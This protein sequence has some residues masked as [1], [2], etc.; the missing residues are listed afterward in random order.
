[1]TAMNV[2]KGMAHFSGSGPE[3]TT[4]GQCNHFLKPSR[5]DWQS[6]LSP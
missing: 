5:P 3:G 4:C 2:I 1:M 6:G